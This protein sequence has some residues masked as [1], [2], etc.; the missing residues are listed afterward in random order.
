LEDVKQNQVEL[1]EMKKHDPAELTHQDNA[2]CRFDF[3]FPVVVEDGRKLT[4]S[5]NVADDLAQV[6][7]AFAKA[8]G[9]PA[10]EIPTIKAF[11][12]HVVT[13][14]KA[15]NEEEAEQDLASGDQEA[16]DL[17]E[18]LKQLEEM[19]LGDGEVLM[20]LLKSYGGSVERVIEALTTFQCGLEEQ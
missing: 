19:G 9:I 5:W 3:T 18:A 12:E 6:A 8:H 4:I 1:A 15:K 16:V 7:V 10:E 14:S 11:L 20:E 17:E 13:M 2:E